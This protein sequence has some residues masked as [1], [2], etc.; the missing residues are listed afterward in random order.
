ME[1]NRYLVFIATLW[2]VCSPVRGVDVVFRY[3]DLTLNPNETDKKVVALFSEL[4]VP[5]SIAVIP[6]DSN[7][8]PIP[9]TDSTLLARLQSSNFEVALHGLTHQD[10]QHKGEFGALN[11]EETYRRIH[12][13]KQILESVTGKTIHTFIPPYNAINT[14]VPM[15]LQRDSVSIMSADMFNTIRG[16]IQYYPETLGHLMEQMG[17]WNAARTTISQC[18]EKD[19]ICVV[20]FHAYDLSTDSDW[21]QLR[22]LLAYCQSSSAVRLFTFSS[23]RASGN[24]SDY[25]RYRANQLENG[26]QKQLLQHGVLHSTW[27]CVVLHL[28]NALLYALLAIPFGMLCY[29]RATNKTWRLAVSICFLLI[30]IGSFLSAWLHILGPLK[31]LAISV[32]TN[33]VLVLLLTRYSLFAQMPKKR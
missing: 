6:C 27:R 3:D 10:L 1:R 31:L 11:E 24:C 13:G 33:G 25:V 17:I 32:V 8:Q 15:A 22:E 21:Q 23:L 18:R 20:M 7:E 14:Y 2:L 9:S 26:L 5:L 4:N 29:R 28:L 16:D 12:K 30:G 19:A